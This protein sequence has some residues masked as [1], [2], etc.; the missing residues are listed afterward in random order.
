MCVYVLCVQATATA[1]Q[2]DGAGGARG[3]FD[4]RERRGGDRGSQRGRGRGAATATRAGAGTGTGR[5]RGWRD[6]DEGGVTAAATAR[7][8]AAA[9]KQ[10]EVGGN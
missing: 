8:G 2:G 3:G 10:R 4:W 1:S 7:D 5:R 6:E 9:M